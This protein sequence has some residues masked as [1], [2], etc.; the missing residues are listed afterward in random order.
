[1]DLTQI[2]KENAQARNTTLNMKVA[3]IAKRYGEGLSQAQ[4]LQNLEA[5]RRAQQ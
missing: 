2:V 5:L 4:Q 1:M 3:E